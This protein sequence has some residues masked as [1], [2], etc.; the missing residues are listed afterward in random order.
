M[1]LFITSGVDDLQ[2][3]MALKILTLMLDFFFFRTKLMSLLSNSYTHR[4][5]FLSLDVLVDI[6]MLHLDFHILV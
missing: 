2:L 6:N 1:H 3:L 5:S 4:Y